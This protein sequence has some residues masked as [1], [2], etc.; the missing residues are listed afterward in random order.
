MPK[1]T[2]EPEA[3]TVYEVRNKTTGASEGR[4]D[5]RKAA[6][7][8]ADRLNREAYRGG[9]RHLGMPVEYEVVTETGVIVSG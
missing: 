5:T 1:K 3:A 2:P 6:D 9:H 4:H 7:R 8:E